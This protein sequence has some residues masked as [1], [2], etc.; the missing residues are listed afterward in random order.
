MVRK[1]YEYKKWYEISLFKKDVEKLWENSRYFR[2][3]SRIVDINCFLLFNEFFDFYW[4]LER[5]PKAQ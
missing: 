4:N 2:F 1:F 5:I 3:I